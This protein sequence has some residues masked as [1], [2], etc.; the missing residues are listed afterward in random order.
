MRSVAAGSRSST[1]GLPGLAGH[2]LVRRR[3]G[4]ARSRRRTRATRRRASVARGERRAAA[5]PTATLTADADRGPVGHPQQPRGARRGPRRCRTGRRRLA[6]RRRRRLRPGT[7]R[8][9]RPAARRSAPSASAAT[10]TRRPSAARRSTG[11]TPTPARPR[12]GPATPSATTTRAWLRPCPTTATRSG[13]RLVHGSPRD[14]LR[15]YVTDAGDRRATTSRARDHAASACTATP[16]S[17]SRSPRSASGSRLV[18][19]RATASALRPRPTVARCST[20]AASASPAT[21]IPRA[22]LRSSSTRPRPTI[23]LASGRLR[24]R[25]RS[26]R[27]CAPSACRRRLAD[28]LALGRDRATMPMIGGRRPLQGRKPGDR[29]VRVERPHAPYFRYTGQGTLT[30]KEAASVPTTPGGAADRARSGR[31]SSAGRSHQRRS[32]ASGCRRSKALAI[33]SSDAIS[34]SAYATEEIILAFTARPA[35][36]LA[37]LAFALAGL[38][39]HRRPAR[40]RRLQLSP[41][42]HRLPER[43]RLV[44]GLEG[45]L[46]PD[47]LARRGLGPA[48]RLQPDRRGLD[49][50][51]GRA[52]RVGRPG[53]R[54][55]AA[56]RSGSLAIGAHHRRQPARPARG[57][58]HLRRPDLP[59]PVQRPAR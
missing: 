2:R 50:V 20:R 44:L 39:R 54:R 42:V 9:G 4:P 3:P 32:S 38:D 13:V 57:R 12:P 56:S 58:Q 17:R 41:G 15:E 48:H 47:R 59:V 53:A 21:A 8:R 29:R 55:R 22:A 25:A 35:S 37:A 11:S 6:P 16:T 10:T 7:R 24:H 43:R 18:E 51:G 14:P 52:D 19:P 23:T 45:E 5:G 49:L 26:R 40:D 31:S 1:P 33:F 27:R 28:R 34:S 36:A 46:R 30:A